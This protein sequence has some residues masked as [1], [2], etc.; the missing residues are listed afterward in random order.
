MPVEIRPGDEEPDGA[1]GVLDIALVNN[2]PDAALRQTE[3]Q[4]ARLLDTAGTDVN[5]RLWRYSLPGVPRGAAA[6]EYLHDQY[7]PIDQLW[8][9]PLA[10]L[11]VTGCEPHA[12][13]LRR[14]PYW[15]GLVELLTWARERTASSIASCLAA[16]A[17][18]LA[19]DGVP[20]RRLAAKLSGVY[21][22]AVQ[23]PHPLTVGLPGEL[24][25]PQSRRNDVPSD[26]LAARGYD[27]L[28]Q[29][30]RVG[31]SV[32]AVDDGGHLRVLTQGHPEYDP[33]TLLL[34]FRRDVRRYLSGELREYPDPPAGYFAQSAEHVLARLR[35][36]ATSGRALGSVEF[37]TDELSKRV[38][39]PWLV[40]ARQLYA[41]WLTEVRRRVSQRVP[42]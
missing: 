21:R 41:N 35:Q 23:H 33:D 11:I 10:A 26:E 19:F 8:D 20:R 22:Q 4:F 3:N 16:H 1:A 34:E 6:A 14:E 32:A 18:V 28:A 29:S 12:A 37:P 27:V 17:A 7:R 25:M 5:I 15:A 9:A 38:T 42:V 2:M 13:D 24:A 40:A 39:A 31:W 36:A 30:T